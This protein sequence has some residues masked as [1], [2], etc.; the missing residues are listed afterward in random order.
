ME[1]AVHF[2]ITLSRIALFIH[3]RLDVVDKIIPVGKATL[4]L[5]PGRIDIKVDLAVGWNEFGTPGGEDTCTFVWCVEGGYKVGR[6]NDQCHSH[7]FERSNRL[8]VVREHRVIGLALS[9]NERHFVCSRTIP[10][11]KLKPAGRRS[12]RTKSS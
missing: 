10:V 5:F 8:F 9:V 3:F 1:P 2:K 6:W 12:T 11:I 4:F 7:L